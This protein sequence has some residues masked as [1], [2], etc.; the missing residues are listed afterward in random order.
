MS[1]LWCPAPPLLW[2]N[3]SL[4]MSWLGP[5]WKWEERASYNKCPKTFTN[6][7]PRGAVGLGPVCEGA[8]EPW[9]AE[10]VTSAGASVSDA[11]WLRMDA[12][13]E[14]GRQHSFSLLRPPLTGNCAQHFI[15]G[16]VRKVFLAAASPTPSRELPM[17]T[18][19]T[20]TG[21]LLKHE[22]RIADS[23]CPGKLL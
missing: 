1:F 22:R 14:W 13:P 16:A 18:Q 10:S 6:M 12:A 21:S 3:P 17:R 2:P 11:R 4:V 19:F 9:E 20:L 23:V 8:Q 15:H 7:Y 5:I